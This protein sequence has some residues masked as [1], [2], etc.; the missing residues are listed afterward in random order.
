[1]KKHL[2]ILLLLSSFIFG[3]NT[4]IDSL[5]ARVESLEQEKQSIDKAVESIRIQI[6]E[7]EFEEAKKNLNSLMEDGLVVK[8]TKAYSSFLV[9]DS[10][11]RKNQI[12]LGTG[13]KVTIYPYAEEWEM[14]HCYKGIY[15]GKVGWLYNLYFDEKDYPG[16]KPALAPMRERAK[17]KKDKRNEEIKR[18]NAEY[19]QNTLSQNSGK[20]IKANNCIEF[21]ELLSADE[22]AIEMGKTVSWVLANWRI[23][24]WEKPSTSGKG[25]KV[26]EMY[27]G[28]YP[29]L[30]RTSGSDYLVVSPLDKSEG[31][32]NKIQAKGIIKKNP[33][34]LEM[35]R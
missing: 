35:C 3:Q 33:V 23:N 34:T 4:K 12:K 30:I 21:V 20:A 22:V 15:D 10:I 17:F 13:K 29:R 19:R 6:E 9:G 16:L 14:G 18:R 32:V 1:M 26:G 28:S 8:T 5:K 25:R 11:S 24:L 2:A 7:L 27:V 31:W